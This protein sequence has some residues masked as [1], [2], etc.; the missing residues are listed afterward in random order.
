M[1]SRLRSLRLASVLARVNKRKREAKKAEAAST[2]QPQEKPALRLVS[3]S[4]QEDGETA[5][6][7]KG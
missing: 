5:R 6:K 7:R 4:G 2:A 3:S 1:S